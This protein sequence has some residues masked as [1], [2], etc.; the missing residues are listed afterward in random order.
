MLSK[1]EIEEKLR[2]IKQSSTEETLRKKRGDKVGCRGSW[3][4]S[5]R[6]DKH[7]LDNCMNIA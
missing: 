1:E 4:H 7:L 2:E 5:K 6:F 3:I